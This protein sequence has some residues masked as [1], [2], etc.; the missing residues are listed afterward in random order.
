MRRI[1]SRTR[2]INVRIM[3]FRSW[4]TT[5]VLHE[6]VSYLDSRHRHLRSLVPQVSN[7]QPPVLLVIIAQHS[8]LAST[9]QVIVEPA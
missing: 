1:L 4:T 9:A 3:R 7:M 6:V 5:D 8:S 2:R